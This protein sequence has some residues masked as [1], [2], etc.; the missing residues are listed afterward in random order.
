MQNGSDSNNADSASTKSAQSDRGNPKF[1]EGLVVSA[2]MA[3]TVV[4]AITR[5][6]KDPQYKKFVKSTTR[7]LAHDEKN[8][9]AVGDL[10]RVIETRP[11]SKNKRWRVHKVVRKA[12]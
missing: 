9:C 1:R 2:K 4:V 7:Y 8:E 12:V 3:K 6:V 11:L 5:Q 10:V